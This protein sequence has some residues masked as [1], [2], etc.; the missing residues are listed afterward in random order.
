VD[1][2]QDPLARVFII[3]NNLSSA[4]ME[5]LVDE[6]LQKWLKERVEYPDITEYAALPGQVM[7]TE[8][9]LNVH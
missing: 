8:C 4:S 2:R 3:Y 9:S 7:F 6:D 5:G 1:P